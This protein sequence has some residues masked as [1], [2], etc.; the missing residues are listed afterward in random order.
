MNPEIWGKHAWFFLHTITLNYPKKP[1]QNDKR[2]YKHFFHLLGHILPC[3]YC[4]YNYN[5]H[6]KKYPIEPFLNKKKHLIIWLINMHNITNNTLKKNN[7]FTYNK[8][9][10]KYKYIFNKQFVTYLFITIA[11]L[12]VL[13]VISFYFDFSQISLKFPSLPSLPQKPRLLFQI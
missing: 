6:I 12:I 3:E 13:L 2:I 8:F 10:S 7:S 1:T 9:Y 11:I 4:K 5:L